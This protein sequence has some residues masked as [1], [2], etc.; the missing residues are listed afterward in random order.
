[1]KN[2]L[3]RLFSMFTNST[4]INKI[5]FLKKI[6]NCFFFF[7][8]QKIYQTD[9]LTFLWEKGGLQGRTRFLKKWKEIKKA[10]AIRKNKAKTHEGKN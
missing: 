2:K 6:E 10:K 9:P 7:K 3:R 4:F 5:L 8:L 1:M